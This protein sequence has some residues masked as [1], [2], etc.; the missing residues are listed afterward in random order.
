MSKVV[1]ENVVP[2]TIAANPNQNTSQL[3]E[4]LTQASNT[5][6]QS[7][8]LSSARIKDYCDLPLS[9]RKKEVTIL[10]INEGSLTDDRTKS[11]TRS[12]QTKSIQEKDEE[13]T[14]SS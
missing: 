14:V 4:A 12:H 2:I 13:E 11:A 10:K 7:S 3:F 5:K 6:N 1:N 8:C 9:N